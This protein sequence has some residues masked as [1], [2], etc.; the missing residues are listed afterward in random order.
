VSE[1]SLFQYYT[2][3]EDDLIEG[4]TSESECD[5]DDSVPITQNFGTVMPNLK[6]LVVVLDDVRGGGLPGSGAKM[7]NAY[8][9][10]LSNEMSEDDIDTI[11]RCSNDSRQVKVTSEDDLFYNSDIST[12]D[13]EIVKPNISIPDQVDVEKFAS[14]NDPR[15]GVDCS[16][17]QIM[18]NNPVT[19]DLTQSDEELVAYSQVDDCIVI[20]NNDDLDDDVIFAN[21]TQSVFKQETDMMMIKEEFDR[22]CFPMRKM[23][24]GKILT[25]MKLY[26]NQVQVSKL[27]N[28]RKK[29]MEIFWPVA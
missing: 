24:S 14:E 29:R 3:S 15:S 28:M 8:T 6:H 11:E 1:N 9:Y 12:A 16:K 20:D 23:I 27:S 4:K 22:T 10:K 17:V 19:E 7:L 13:E 18:E 26:Q 25:S 21:L 2:D 5:S